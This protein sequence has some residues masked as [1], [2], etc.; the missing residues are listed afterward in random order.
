[1]AS[2]T[3]FE[4]LCQGDLE[5]LARDADGA[6][7]ATHETLRALTTDQLEKIVE[8]LGDDP[9]AIKKA[10]RNM[11]A[12]IRNRFNDKRH[13]DGLC[14]NM[15][16]YHCDYMKAWKTY[17]G[18]IKGRDISSKLCMTVAKPVTGQ[19]E[20]LLAMCVGYDY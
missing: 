4:V 18:E 5:E 15:S 6:T 7:G 2:K 17:R 8:A 1:M 14:P 9:A 3:K 13:V 12:S 10:G 16:M 20:L 11:Q 19:T